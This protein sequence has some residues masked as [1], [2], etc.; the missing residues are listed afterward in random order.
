[1]YINIT[2][3]VQFFWWCVC[4][5]RLATLHWTASKEAYSWE[6]LILCLLGVIVSYFVGLKY[7]P[8]KHHI[9]LFGSLKFMLKE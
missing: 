9:L 8:S 1:M 5:F 4:S 2:C 3:R 7:T 6:K